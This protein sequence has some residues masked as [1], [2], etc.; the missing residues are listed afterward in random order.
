MTALV[1]F[2]AEQ[3]KPRFRVTDVPD[4]GSMAALLCIAKDLCVGV[5]DDGFAIAVNGRGRPACALD[6]GE[7]A[8]TAAL[9]PDG[10]SFVVARP[11][12]IERYRANGDK[13][14]ALEVAEAT[15]LAYAADCRM[16]YA[17]DARGKLV[18]LTLADG[19][20]ITFFMGPAHEGSVRGMRVLRTGDVLSWG[21]SAAHLWDGATGRVRHVFGGASDLLDVAASP[22]ASAVAMLDRKTRAL[23]VYDAMTGSETGGWTAIAPPAACAWGKRLA[24]GDL[25]GGV[26][27]FA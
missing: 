12:R 7:R 6:T 8:R 14:P 21:A 20:A 19:R 22:D 10:S 25:D 24:V 26:Y 1:G 3:D 15:A 23:R 18:A 5:W 17:G 4:N 27:F 2:A 11:A 16:L 9:A 13:L